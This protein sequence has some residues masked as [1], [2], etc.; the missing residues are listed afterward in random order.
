MTDVNEIPAPARGTG[1]PSHKKA[2]LS[3][4]QIAALSADEKEQ[5]IEELEAAL[6]ELRRPVP[7]PYP[8]WV[9]IGGV[10]QVVESPEDEERKTQ[11]DAAFHKAHK[12]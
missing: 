7:Q 3:A 10:P 6:V 8:K 5:L 9:E 12:S 4:E 1:H 2:G 11:A